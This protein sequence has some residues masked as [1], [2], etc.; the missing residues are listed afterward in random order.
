MYDDCP[1]QRPDVVW[2]LAEKFKALSSIRCSLAHEETQI[3]N[4]RKIKRK[5]IK[6]MHED[7]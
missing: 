6:G 7:K 2:G 5:T 4:K 1:R 3:K